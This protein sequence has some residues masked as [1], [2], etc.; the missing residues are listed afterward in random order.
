MMTDVDFR[1]WCEREYWT[2]IQAAS[3]AAG[4]E[5]LNHPRD[6]DYDW[7]TPQGKIYSDL[8]DAIKNNEIE[9]FEAE[10][11]GDQIWT[12]DSEANSCNSA[13]THVWTYYIRGFRM[14]NFQLFFSQD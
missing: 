6:F 5:P 7:E 4:I 9:A 2:L 14:H 13:R 8:K 12:A 10:R 11:T 3:I 1:K